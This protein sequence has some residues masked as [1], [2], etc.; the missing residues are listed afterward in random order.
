[1]LVELGLLEQRHK[2]VLEVMNGAMVTEVAR[3]YGVVR[4]TVH[5]WLRRYAKAGVAGLL[6]RSCTPAHCPHQMPAEVEARVCAL[7]RQHPGWGPQR[8]LHELAK[9][10]PSSATTS[11]SPTSAVASGRTSSAGSGPGR[12]SC[13]RWTSWAAS[14]SPTT[15]RPPS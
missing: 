13:G 6:D 8:L 1:M 5:D 12:W 10:G 2:A 4:Q 7:R 14:N 9:T 11:S 3:R 15:A